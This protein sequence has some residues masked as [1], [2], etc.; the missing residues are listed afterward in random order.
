ML[1]AEA[2]ESGLGTLLVNYLVLIPQQ[3]S[4]ADE[5]GGKE[6]QD[7]YMQ[8]QWRSFTL[9]FG[10]FAAGLATCTMSR[11]VAH[12][13]PATTIEAPVSVAFGQEP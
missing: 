9:G 5:I 11:P 10:V 7:L 13:S 6:I 4:S 12:C 1:A 3:V 8:V 2:E